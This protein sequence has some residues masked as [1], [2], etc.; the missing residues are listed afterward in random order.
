MLTTPVKTIANT[1]TFYSSHSEMST[2]FPPS[3]I[4]KVNRIIAGKIIVYSG[5]LQSWFLSFQSQ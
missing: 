2:I 4:N 1:N 5:E 3:T